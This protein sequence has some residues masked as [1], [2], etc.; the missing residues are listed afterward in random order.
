MARL[1]VKILN[2]QESDTFSMR[3]TDDLNQLLFRVESATFD[4]HSLYV[5]FR[6]A[7][8]SS[9][10]RKLIREDEDYLRAHDL[11]V[12]SGSI[13]FKDE[14]G[15]DSN[16]ILKI[17]FWN[18]YDKIQKQ[19]LEK[20]IHLVNQKYFGP[21]AQAADIMVPEEQLKK[22][23][24]FFSQPRRVAGYSVYT[25]PILFRLSVYEMRLRST[26]LQKFL[27][28]IPLFKA[29]AAA[30]V[31]ELVHKV[32][33]KKNILP[34][35]FHE[36]FEG[37]WLH[38][39][40]DVP[41]KGKQLEQQVQ[42]L[43]Q[44]L[45]IAQMIYDFIHSKEFTDWLALEFSHSKTNNEV[46]LRP[47]TSEEIE[48]LSLIHPSHSGQNYDDQ[49]TLWHNQRGHFR[50]EY[51]LKRNEI[52]VAL[53]LIKTYPSLT[54]ELVEELVRRENIVTVEEVYGQAVQIEDKFQIIR[55]LIRFS[56][57][58]KSKQD[59]LRYFKI[60]FHDLKRNKN[61]FYTPS[62][63][64]LLSFVS[65]RFPPEIVVSFYQELDALKRDRMPM[66]AQAEWLT[67]FLQNNYI[68]KYADYLQ[69]AITAL[70]LSLPAQPSQTLIDRIV[71][72]WEALQ[73]TNWTELK[74]NSIDQLQKV[75][76][77][78]DYEG[79]YRKKMKFPEDG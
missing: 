60:F 67:F 22:F 30:N 46:K 70:F 36:Q 12:D 11:A 50:L 56:A 14:V 59:V 76:K 47:Y 27:V 10:Q 2:L 52:P 37:L 69:E 65:R 68:E 44:L 13:I 72:L 48:R 41:G 64:G 79:Y 55:Q 62:L 34:F 6:D 17:P 25:Q 73:S 18:F 63:T 21:P 45:G 28:E 32:L 49:W 29:S 51:F 71:L 43:H 54:T 33:M 74:R 58:K 7:I 53:D 61:K 40:W 23:D 5:H 35:A 19:R 16:R 39:T 42:W 77:G 78:M 9:L 75:I 1:D 3:E 66:A 15:N 20:I 8:N 24:Q 4:F 38:Y 57:H 31:V 26:A